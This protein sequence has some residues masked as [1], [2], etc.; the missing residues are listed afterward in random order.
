MLFFLDDVQKKLGYVFDDPMVLRRCFTH[1]SYTN[2]HKAAPHNQ[3]LEFLG[4][5]V[6]GFIVASKLYEI[7]PE[8][9]D[10]EMT[11]FKQS[12]VSSA[13]LAAA[14]KKTG[15]DKYLLVGENAAGE[16]TDKMREDLFEAIVG[17]LYVDGGIAAAEKFI[18]EN[19][20]LKRNKTEDAKSALNEYCAKKRLGDVVYKFVSRSGADNSPSFTMALYIGGKFVAEGV[21]GSK[22]SAEQAAAEFALNGLS[23]AKTE[24]HRV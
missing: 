19:L 9:S 10:G 11:K 13:P 12:V 23:R 17:A 20:P 6:L 15:L 8:L 21:G 3:R 24:S 1:P 16:V 7:T 18:I 5:S 14:V 4:D 2:E 22:K